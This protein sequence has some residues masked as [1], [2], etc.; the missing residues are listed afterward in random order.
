M[1]W[2]VSMSELSDPMSVA[3]QA[4]PTLASFA[5]EGVASVINYRTN[6]STS[7]ECGHVLKLDRTLA[8]LSDVIATEA[9]ICRPAR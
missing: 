1:G 7:Y 2:E 6:E 8:G 4:S 3:P 5:L 9:K